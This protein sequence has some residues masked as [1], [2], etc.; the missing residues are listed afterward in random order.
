MIFVDYADIQMGFRCYD[1]VSG[2]TLISQD[3]VFLEPKAAKIDSKI[4]IDLFD[5]SDKNEP[6][7]AVGAVSSP[8]DD[9]ELRRSKRIRNSV[10]RPDFITYLLM[11]VS[12][13]IR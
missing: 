8:A 12:K 1:P 10:V 6:T 13:M 7:V 5:D 3:V 11:I 9:V 4:T 2:R